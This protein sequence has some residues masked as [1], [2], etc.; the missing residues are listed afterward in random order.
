MTS[1]FKRYRDDK[2]L[3]SV[4]G[5]KF[6][7]N[8]FYNYIIFSSLE[9]HH[10]LKYSRILTLPKIKNQHHTYYCIFLPTYIFTKIQ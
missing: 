1:G 10:Q 7:I 9:I 8:L 6:R 3:L 4:Y 5:K 2:Y